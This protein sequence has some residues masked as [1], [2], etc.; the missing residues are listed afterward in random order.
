M[1]KK[2]NF[3]A[4][5]KALAQDLNLDESVSVEWELRY[6]LTQKIKESFEDLH[7][8]LSQ[9][10]KKA[11]VSPSSLQKIFKGYSVGISIETL[12]RILGVLG[13]SIKVSFRKAA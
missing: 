9:L 2:I 11:K 1:K 4:S 12:L 10:S 13:Q 7:W 8:T 5:T 6:S 3:S